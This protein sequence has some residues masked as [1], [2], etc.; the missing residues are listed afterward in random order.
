MSPRSKLDRGVRAR[1]A[2]L[3]VEMLDDPAASAPSL[4]RLLDAA[5]VAALLGVPKSWVYSETRAGR[6]PHVDVGRYRR[7]R[8]EAIESWIAEHERGPVR[9]PRRPRRGRFDRGD[10]L[11]LD[12]S[13]AAS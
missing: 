3:S 10:Q 8:R 6:L 2:S 13:G 4:D 7:Y 11:R 1:R 9:G 5:E 12:G